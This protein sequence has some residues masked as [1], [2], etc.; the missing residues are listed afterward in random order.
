MPFEAVNALKKAERRRPT[1]PGV[2]QTDFIINSNPPR[3]RH[4][5]LLNPAVKKAFD[6]RVDRKQIIDV[7][8]AR[9]REP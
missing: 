5:E 3:R 4:R 7:V 6:V 2:D 8:F 1:V 9:L